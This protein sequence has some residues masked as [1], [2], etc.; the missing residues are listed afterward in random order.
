MKYFAITLLK[1]YKVTLSKL[2]GRRCIYTP[3]CSVY[4]MEAY[5]SYG[6]ILGTVLTAKRLLRCAPWGKGGFDPVPYNK[7][8]KGKWFL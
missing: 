5:D 8:G 7:K 4:G 3:T 6:V 1:I 2:F